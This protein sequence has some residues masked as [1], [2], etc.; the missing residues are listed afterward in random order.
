MVTGQ[1]YLTRKQLGYSIPVWEGID[2]NLK[3]ELLAMELWLPDNYR[4]FTR[5]NRPGSM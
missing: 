1:A 3:Q 2:P 4:S 5:D